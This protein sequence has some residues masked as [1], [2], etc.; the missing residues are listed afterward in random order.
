[1]TDAAIGI[2]ARALT[3]FAGLPQL[4][5]AL[6]TRSSTDLSLYGLIMFGTGVAIWILYGLRIGALPIVIWNAITL[7]IYCALIGVRLSHL[8]AK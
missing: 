1:V 8:Q 5:R 7:V 2:V 4:I 6:R 3:T